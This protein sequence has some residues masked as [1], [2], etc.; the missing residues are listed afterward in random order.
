MSMSILTYKVLHNLDLTTELQKAI[1]VA[2]YSLKH[3][4]CRTT[5]DVK[6]IGLKACISNQILKKYGSNKKLKSVKKVKLT[7]NGYFVKL[8]KEKQEISV[9][10]VKLKLNYQ[11]PNNFIKINQVE[12]DHKYI[13]VAVEISNEKEIEI[14]GYLGID[15]NTTG[16]CCVAASPQNGKVYKLG[17][18]GFHY[19]RKYKKI[20]MR[21]Q[22][23][24]AKR[25]L[26]KI[27]KREKNI[28]KD[29]NH[30]A[31]KTIINLAKKN[32][33]GIVLEDLKGIRKN[34][35]RR[36]GKKNKN[37]E[38]FKS[39]INTWEFYQLQSM[40]EYKAK[41]C[42]IPVIYVDPHFTSQRCSKCGQLG[43]RNNKKF[44]CS[45]I[46]CGHVD[47]A[48]ANAAFNIAALAFMNSQ[49][50]NDQSAVD[51][52]AAEG[53]TD[54]PRLETQQDFASNCECLVA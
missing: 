29:V 6:Y 27:S 1:R 31:S 10:S 44:S 3:R 15:R 30:K 39:S 12:L 35:K 20:R 50:S 38:S 52:V 22:K 21:L 28:V 9:P 24:N 18:K 8:D 37:G 13:Y 47:H 45:N 23:A 53:S 48:D 2:N 32:S 36:S 43:E 7:I 33:F 26:K 54:T 5:K 42:G 14:K 46:N 11:F 4:K 49:G 40:I 17:K 34:T 16:H 25:M 19:H 41:I 51:R